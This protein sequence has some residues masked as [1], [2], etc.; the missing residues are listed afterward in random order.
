MALSAAASFPN[1]LIKGRSRSL[2]VC[3]DPAT[4]SKGDVYSLDWGA[5]LGGKFNHVGTRSLS[6]ADPSPSF[7][8][9]VHLP[10]ILIKD[11]YVKE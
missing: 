2:C 5:M 11:W 8:K 4:S 9:Y 10:L 3:F 6:Y 1:Y 7:G